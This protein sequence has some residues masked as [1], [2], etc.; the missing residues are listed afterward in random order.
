MD[1]E[2]EVRRMPSCS[3]L[4]LTPREYCAGKRRVEQDGR[5]GEREEEEVDGRITMAGKRRVE[6]D[7]RTGGGRG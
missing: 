2:E 7:G 6:Q 1:V 4:H 5:T 3:T